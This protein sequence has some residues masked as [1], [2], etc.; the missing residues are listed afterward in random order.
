MAFNK[1]LFCAEV[2][3]RVADVDKSAFVPVPDADVKDEGERTR[4]YKEALAR[5]LAAKENAI[6]DIAI[7]S[8]ASLVS[9]L[10]AEVFKPEFFSGEF[11]TNS[12]VKEAQDA[13]AIGTAESL[14]D[15]ALALL[16]AGFLK[17]VKE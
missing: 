4:L 9:E 17:L 13:I 5:A 1:I 12:L 15:A 7:H 10:G 11:D 16:A 8:S 2:K 6:K 14:A 3:Q